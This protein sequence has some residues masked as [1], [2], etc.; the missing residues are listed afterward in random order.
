MSRS[1]RALSLAL[2]AALLACS[3]ASAT[4]PSAHATAAAATHHTGK[5]APSGVYYE[6]FVRSWYDTNGDG[7]GDLNGVTAKLDYLKSLGINAIW[8]MPINPSPSYHGYDITNYEAINPQYGSMAD[9]EHLVAAAHQRGI[10]IIMD[11]VVNHTSSDH[12]WFKQAQNP[13][14]PYRHWYTWAGPKT[15]LKA[16]S[17]TG[18]PLWHKGKDGHYLGVF[19]AE[20]PDLNYDNP[21]VRKAIIG[22]GKFWMK[23]G[24]DG[25]RLD[26]ARHIYDDHAGDQ[27][28]PGPLAKNVA[29]WKQFAHGIDTHG[30]HAY[31]VGEVSGERYQQLAPYLASLDAV[32]NF[33]LAERLIKAA[34]SGTRGDLA[35][36]LPAQA[37]AYRRAAGARRAD[38]IFL[39]N[40]DQNRVM[41]QLGDNMAKMRLAASLLL[42]LPGDAYVYYGEEL[43]MHGSKPDPSIREPMRWDR[44]LNGHGQTHWE[45]AASN[46][47]PDISV[48]AEK[49]RSDSL[50]T[51]YQQLAT[52]RQQISALRDGAL[53]SVP[54]ADAHLWAYTLGDAHSHVLVVHNLSGQPRSY[55]LP[56]SVKVHAL[57]H[58]T[59]PAA[60]LAA[61][62]LQLPPYTTVILE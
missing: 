7:I 51:L 43:G 19:T 17:A 32:F 36:W 37:A 61:R 52:W 49:G 54:A 39:S 33:P 25:F 60:L 10:K 22:V 35:S 23:K 53:A 56:P 13:A 41:D 47:S 57:L 38:A 16:I 9:F 26:A 58:S 31:L 46:T 24:V 40:H 2:G 45:K 44:S 29:W 15:H 34:D 27:D 48:Q 11:L 6:I 59:D 28:K 62:T 18:G 8:L 20:M 3:A 42:T 12:P 14:S 4:V 30:R 50:L 1:I 5:V 21:A 55:P